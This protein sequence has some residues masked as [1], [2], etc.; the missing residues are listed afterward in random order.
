MSGKRQL[1]EGLED[2]VRELAAL[3]LTDGEIGERLGLKR[4]TVSYLRRA[5]GIAPG[6]GRVGRAP[7]WQCDRGRNISRERQL[8]VSES[9][10]Y[11]AD[12]P[13]VS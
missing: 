11:P 5:N 6:L 2:R 1:P 4:T 9:R 8:A 12:P 3:R 10:P 7:N 13:E